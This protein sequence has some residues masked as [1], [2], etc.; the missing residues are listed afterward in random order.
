MSELRR[1]QYR[2]PFWLW[3]LRE[4][5]RNFMMCLRKER[6]R[7]INVKDWGNQ[8]E[9]SW[10][11]S[12]FWKYIKKDSHCNLDV[13]RILTQTKIALTEKSNSVVCSLDTG[14]TKPLSKGLLMQWSWKML[15]TIWMARAN[16]KVL[17]HTKSSAWR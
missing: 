13:R 9:K 15:K 10:P 17:N 6:W 4:R 1:C 11:V 3:K 2:W 8:N 16:N 7:K 5:R 14:K 12:L